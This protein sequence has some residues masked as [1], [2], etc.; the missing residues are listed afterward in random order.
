MVLMVG[1]DRKVKQVPMVCQDR[2]E[3]AME[4]MDIVDRMVLLD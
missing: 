4:R 1:E 3:L 2:M